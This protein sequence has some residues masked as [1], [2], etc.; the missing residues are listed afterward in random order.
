M[1]KDNFSDFE[2]LKV[3]VPVREECCKLLGTF[4]TDVDCLLQTLPMIFI[5]VENDI[6]HSKLNFFL[7]IKG[8]AIKGEKK[9]KETLLMMFGNLLIQALP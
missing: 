2:G 8:L 3:M 6:W 7:I 4:G 5:A 9:M 1:L